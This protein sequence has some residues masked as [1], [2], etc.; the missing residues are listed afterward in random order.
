LV[1]QDRALIGCS[2][3]AQVLDELQGTVAAG[4]TMFFVGQGEGREEVRV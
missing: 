2:S 3:F 1:A 4:V